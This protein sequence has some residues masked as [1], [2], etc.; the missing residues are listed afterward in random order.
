MIETHLEP[1]VFRFSLLAREQGEIEVGEADKPPI[2][3]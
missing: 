3:G 2:F 1:P